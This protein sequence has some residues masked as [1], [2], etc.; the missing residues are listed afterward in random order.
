M[1]KVEIDME[2]DAFVDYKE[3][4]LAM[5]LRHLAN[6][7]EASNLERELRDSNGN[8]VGFSFVE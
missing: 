7:V 6:E 8:R 2:N 1:F 3:Q 4:E 5:I